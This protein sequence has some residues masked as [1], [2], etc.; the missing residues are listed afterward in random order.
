MFSCNQNTATKTGNESAEKKDTVKA[1][2]IKTIFKQS[3]WY[4]ENLKGKV[5]SY[6]DTVYN[7]L[8][9]PGKPEPGAGIRRME[10]VYDNYGLLSS[11]AN[12]WIG[13][14]HGVSTDHEYTY[15][16][17]TKGNK[18]E[19]GGSGT[20]EVYQYDERGNML[21]RSSYL[22]DNLAEKWIYKYDT[23]GNAVEEM[24]FFGD[25]SGKTIDKY[26][27]N[28]EGRRIQ[29]IDFSGDVWRYKYDAQGNLIGQDAGITKWTY[30]Y[31]Y[32]QA[33]NWVKKIEFDT[34]PG[35]SNKPQYIT[36]RHIVYY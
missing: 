8:D 35:E 16:Y 7:A 24:H 10:N 34:S 32:D 28:K 5:K 19:R 25:G 31:E 17:D 27:Y 15:R 6:I 4:A 18:T 13:P 3:D 23:A 30:Q 29:R 21:E 36:Q 22:A 33:G 9:V 14:G 11:A 26:K 1:P 2:E 12:I 20:K